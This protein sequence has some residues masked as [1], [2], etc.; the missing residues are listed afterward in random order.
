MY[1][2]AA[3]VMFGGAVIAPVVLRRRPERWRNCD[4]L[5]QGRGAGD[6]RHRSGLSR[7]TD[8]WS[9]DWWS[10]DWWSG[11]FATAP[12]CAGAQLGRVQACAYAVEPQL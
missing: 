7:S 12:A 11:G 6:E 3:I 10:T 4:A 5:A 2:G 8:R 1:G 9:T